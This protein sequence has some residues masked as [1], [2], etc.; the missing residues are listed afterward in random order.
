MPQL[1]TI[2]AVIALTLGMAG[3]WYLRKKERWCSGC[4]ATLVCG[5]GCKAARGPAGTQ[6]SGA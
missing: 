1:I 6:G 2:T 4:G 5:D 3:G